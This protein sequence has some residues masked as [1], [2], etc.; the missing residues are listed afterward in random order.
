MT[1]ILPNVINYDHATS[2]R[3]VGIVSGDTTA[4]FEN[5]HRYRNAI[6]LLSGSYSGIVKL[7][8]MNH[9][10]AD[11]LTLT[12]GVFCDLRQYPLTIWVWPNVVVGGT[13]SA[14]VEIMFTNEGK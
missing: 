12:P 11:I 2:V 4:G 7:R 8:G 9:T 13:G 1:Q 5:A 10:E 3:W 6:V 14:A